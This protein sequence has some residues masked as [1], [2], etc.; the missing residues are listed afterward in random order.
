MMMPPDFE[1][2]YPE[3]V[4]LAPFYQKRVG[5]TLRDVINGLFQRRMNPGDDPDA[6]SLYQPIIVQAQHFDSG[7]TTGGATDN[8]QAVRAPC[9]VV[10]PNLCR[11]V[12]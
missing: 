12:E 11:R 2:T 6:A 9:E 10:T 7:P 4:Q 8:A 3:I 5:H 1:K